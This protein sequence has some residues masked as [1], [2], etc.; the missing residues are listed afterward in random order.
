MAT[1]PSTDHVGYLVKQV[2]H[3]LRAFE[4]LADV[5]PAVLIQAAGER[6]GEGRGHVLHDGDA[7]AG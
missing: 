5:D 1:I 7:G 3:G 6:R 4:A 2:Q